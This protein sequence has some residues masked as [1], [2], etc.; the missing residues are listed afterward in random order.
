MWMSNVFIVVDR[1]NADRNSMEEIAAAVACAGAN[2]VGIDVQ[3]HLIE[4]TV[5]CARGADRGG[6]GRRGV[7]PIRFHLP[8]QERIRRS[9]LGRGVGS[10]C[11][12]RVRGRTGGRAVLRLWHGRLARAGYQLLHGRG[13]SWHV[14][15]HTL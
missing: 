1:N 15:R 3:T 7:R 11:V 2:I 5:P 4:A 6:H 14:R 9:G 8:L 10:W 12:W 13:G